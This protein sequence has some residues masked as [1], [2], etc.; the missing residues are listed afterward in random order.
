MQAVRREV[1][2]DVNHIV[3]SAQEL[4]DWRY[5]VRRNPWLCVGGAFALGVLASP[6]R[7]QLLQSLDG[8]DLKTLLGQA[9]GV[10]APIAAATGAGG[11]A[12]KVLAFVG[13]IVA[14]SAASYLA[15]RL[16]GG[17]PP[18]DDD[19]D[20]SHLEQAGRPR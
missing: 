8:V 19:E 6:K 2:A 20:R 18:A 7:R 17:T 5:Y 3:D 12:M 14:R 16:G 4:S 11:V 1:S 9:G 13:P 15:Q 10:A